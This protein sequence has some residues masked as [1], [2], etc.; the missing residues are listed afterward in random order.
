MVVQTEAEQESHDN[1]TFTYDEVNN[2]DYF[3]A[4]FGKKGKNI[5]EFEDAKNI[6]YFS[7]D[8]VIIADF[9]NSRLQICNESSRTITVFAPEEI[10]LP[11]ATAVTQENKIAVTLSKYRCVKVINMFGEVTNTFGKDYFVRPTGLAVDRDGNFVVCDSLTDK[12]SMFDNDGNFIR[13]IGNPSNKEE[14]FSNPSYVCVSDTGDIIVSDTGHHKLKIFSSKGKYIR[15]VG[16]F[17]KGHNQFKSPYGVTTNKCGDIFVADHY[18]SRISMFTRDGVFVR[19]IV[20]SE[21]GLVHPQ[22]LTISED[23]H[24]YITHGHLK[25]SEILKF[26]LTNDA[27]YKSTHALSHL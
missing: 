18:N 14:C 26:K 27:E 2:N 9:V 6:T 24:L 20:T 12:V 8:Q 3:V 13:F 4:V 16:S 5:G 11:W 1:K 19:H 25:A 7:R 10:N 15:S 23:L 22:G 21:H 17:G